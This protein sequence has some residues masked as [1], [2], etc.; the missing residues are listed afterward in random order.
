[1]TDKLACGNGDFLLIEE[2]ETLEKTL[3]DCHFFTTNPTWNG[4]RIN[5]VFGARSVD[6]IPVGVRFFANV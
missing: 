1:M 5:P 2:T 6:R 3:I 4:L